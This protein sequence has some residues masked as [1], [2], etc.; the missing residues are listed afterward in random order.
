[1]KIKV[2]GMKYP[3]NIKA[4][5]SLG[6]DFMGFIFYPK[7]VRYFEGD[8]SGIDFKQ[9]KKVGVF[10]DEEIKKLLQI[11]RKY[12][13]DYLQLHGKESPEYVRKLKKEGYEVIKVFSVGKDFDF[14]VCRSYMADADMFLF[15]TKGKLPGGNGEQ[16]DWRILEKY[17]LNKPFLLS[18]GIGLEHAF[19]VKNFKHPQCVGVDVNSGFEIEP[20]LKNV[21][22]LTGFIR[23]L[24]AT[25]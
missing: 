22:K 11:A 4:V 20:G 16:F 1:M 6:I 14:G 24:S 13:L 5:L 25:R 10:V 21:V 9:T 3:G 17:D 7:S 2:C 15:D 12:G 23:Q 19:Q 18:G 8:L